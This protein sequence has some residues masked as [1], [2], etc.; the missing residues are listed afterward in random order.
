MSDVVRII[1]QEQGCPL[2]S[3]IWRKQAANTWAYEQELHIRQAYM[4][5]A[6]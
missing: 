3:G 1:S 4:E 6:A 2:R 5:N